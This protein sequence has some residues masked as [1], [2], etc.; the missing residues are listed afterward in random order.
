M[1]EQEDDDS[2]VPDIAKVRPNKKAILGEIEVS[3]YGTE[4]I[5]IEHPYME[6]PIPVGP[7]EPDIFW[8]D[9]SDKRRI[10]IVLDGLL[11]SIIWDDSDLVAAGE[12]ADEVNE[13]KEKYGI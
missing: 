12:I 4:M 9:Y 1:T 5:M 8:S 3:C 13:Q 7:T 2:A 10:E 6:A 11:D